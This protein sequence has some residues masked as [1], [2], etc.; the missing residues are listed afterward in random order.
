MKLVDR[1][2]TAGKVA[3]VESLTVTCLTKEIAHD[4]YTQ[5]TGQVRLAKHTLMF[6]LKRLAAVTIEI[7]K[8][9]YN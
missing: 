7:N 6:E 9:R 2:E 8:L 3:L 1:R 5:S 4:A